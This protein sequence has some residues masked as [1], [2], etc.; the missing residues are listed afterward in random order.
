[1]P[2]YTSHGWEIPGSVENHPMP[3][4]SG[5]CRGPKHCPDCAKEAAEWNIPESSVGWTYDQTRHNDDT[6]TKVDGVLRRC[7]LESM[8]SLWAIIALQNEGI[9]FRERI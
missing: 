1:M 7:G 2:A 3:V 8:A 9:L 4:K 5:Q 6:L